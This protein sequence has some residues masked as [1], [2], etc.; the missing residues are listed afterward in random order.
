MKLV[1]VVEVMRTVWRAELEGKAR[2]SLYLGQ[3]LS[4]YLD[5]GGRT[6][7]TNHSNIKTIS[8]AI[9][10]RTKL[11]DLNYYKPRMESKKLKMLL[12]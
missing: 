2:T 11:I 6:V 4:L 3:Y 7:P 5:L 10:A 1:R 8:S 12:K 9:K